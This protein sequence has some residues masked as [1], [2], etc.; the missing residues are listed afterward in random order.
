M[1]GDTS[2]TQEIQEIQ[3]TQETADT[4]IYGGFIQF[5]VQLGNIAADW[6]EKTAAI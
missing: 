3:E 5:D 1:S 6:T 2:G 4:R